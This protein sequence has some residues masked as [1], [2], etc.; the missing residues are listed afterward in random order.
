M[1]AEERRQKI[2]NILKE[3]EFL[4]AEELADMCNVS[5]ITIIRDIKLLKE[6]QKIKKI[7]G[8]ISILDS[9]KNNFETRFEIRI[10]DNYSKKLDI[11]SKALKHISDNQT[12][13]LDSSSTVFVLASEIFKKEMS[14]SNF[15]TNSPSIIV[16]ALNHPQAGLICTG[17]ELKQEFNIFGG[18]WVIEFLQ[19]INLDAAFVSAAGVSENGTITTNNKDLA[20]ILKKVFSKAKTINLL[21]DSSKF[22]KKGM[23]DIAKLQDC[24]RIITDNEISEPVLK[25]LE[26]ITDS[27]IIF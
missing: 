9:A 6:A 26:R 18:D 11:A 1:L 7:H 25:R 21:I 23:L 4:R 16:D 12:I 5:R 17:G 10:R 13:F 8:G 27:E 3:K 2:I 14:Q 24:H 22:F 15:I 19:N 20:G